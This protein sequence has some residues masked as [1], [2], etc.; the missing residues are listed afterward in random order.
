LESKKGKQRGEGEKEDR[1][2]EREREEG[3][4]ERGTA[5]FP[6]PHAFM[7]RAT[8]FM[9]SPALF[10]KIINMRFASSFPQTKGKINK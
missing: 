10:H 1:E 9:K 2:R 7:F 6:G 5:R 8:Q 3:W 4:R